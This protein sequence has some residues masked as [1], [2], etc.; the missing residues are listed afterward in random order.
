MRVYL[1]DLVHIPNVIALPDGEDP[2]AGYTET[3]DAV[4]IANLGL[5]AAKLKNPGWFDKKCVRD[6]LRE[7]IYLRMGITS[8]ADVEDPDKWNNLSNEEKYVAT[9]WFLVAKHEFQNE[10]V[11]NRRYWS[12]EALKYREWSMEVRRARLGLMEGLVFTAIQSLT[13]AKQILKDLEQ[14]PAGSEAFEFDAEGKLVNKVHIKSLS[15]AYVEGI[16]ALSQDGIIGL[17]DFINS[18][19][20]TPFEGNGFRSYS[21][22]CRGGYTIDSLADELV[23]IIDSKW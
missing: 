14:I 18:E 19:V 2:P 15:K 7:L 1:E 22:T 8:P 6:K 10:I 11:N 12:I 23:D 13:D 9:H 3:T 17:R 4:K 5:D 20:G 16:Q 21:Y